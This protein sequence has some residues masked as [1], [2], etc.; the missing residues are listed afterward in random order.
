MLSLV[1]YSS[2][3]E[4]DNIDEK[5]NPLPILQKEIPQLPLPLRL[6]NN[7]LNSESQ[8]DKPEDHSGRIR[9]FPHERGNWAT[10]GFIP[11]LVIV[12]NYC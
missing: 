12:D 2:S 3:E 5:N 6:T 7:L 10:Y 9:S 4:S 8:N 11:C 1:D